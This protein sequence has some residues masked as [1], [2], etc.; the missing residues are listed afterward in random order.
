MNEEL[1]K[2]ILSEIWSWI[3][4]IFIAVCLALFITNYIIVNARVPTGSMSTTIKPEDRLV[5]NRLSYLF[6][7]PQRGDII[8]FPFPDSDPEEELVL[9]V[10]RIVGM[11][12]ETIEIIE[13][14]VYINGEKL[15]EPY[16]S[17]T[18]LFDQAYNMEPMVIPDD[19]YFM[20]GDNRGD[21]EDSRY[22]DNKFLDKDNI[23]GKALF[24]Y[25]PLPGLLK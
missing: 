25:Y 20:M 3:K 11:P 9:Y 13:G 22:W 6:T 4:T 15:V 7:A 17:S 8:V 18:P 1:K 24:K 14:E 10:K 23:V 21:S 12:N 5:A 16:T 19:H 2:E